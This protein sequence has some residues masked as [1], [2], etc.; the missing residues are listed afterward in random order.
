MQQSSA[1]NLNNELFFKAQSKLNSYG[2]D[3]NKALNDYLE[4][5]ISEGYKPEQ[6]IKKVP[7]I[8]MAELCGIFKGKLW[9]S[10]DFDEPLEDMKEYME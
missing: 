3:V 5:I 4:K 9:T 6:R 1:I 10:D 8:S 2:I 7:E